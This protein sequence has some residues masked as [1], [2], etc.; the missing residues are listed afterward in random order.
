MLL[1][2]THVL[3]WLVEGSARLGKVAGSAI[4]DALKNESLA[5]ATMS[6]WEI[7]MLVE[8]RRLHMATPLDVWRGELLRAGLVEIPLHGAT[9]IRAAQLPSFHGDPADRLLVATALYHQA[10][11]V[12]GDTRILSWTP[13][14]EKLDARR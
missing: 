6:F 5:I 12:T 7:A 13:L 10:T 2:D 4:D 3:I 8:K 1:L 14:E 9:A 11:F